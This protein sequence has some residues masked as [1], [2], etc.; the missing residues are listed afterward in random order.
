MLILMPLMHMKPK[1]QVN[2]S[3]RVRIRSQSVVQLTQITF[4]SCL[5]II[6]K[7]SIK[8]FML[9]KKAVTSSFIV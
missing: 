4:K 9:K 1:L 5:K 2:I 6:L 7:R 8:A 3:F